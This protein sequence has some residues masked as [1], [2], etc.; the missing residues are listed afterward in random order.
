MFQTHPFPF[1]FVVKKGLSVTKERGTIPVCKTLFSLS[2]VTEQRR[3]IFMTFEQLIVHCD[4]IILIT[5][6]D[7]YFNRKTFFKSKKLKEIDL[8]CYSTGPQSKQPF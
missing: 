5:E 1:L 6:R 2:K 3:V 4:Y 7:L 8:Y